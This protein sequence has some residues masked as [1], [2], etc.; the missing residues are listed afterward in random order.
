[1]FWL[2]SLLV[3]SVRPKRTGQERFLEDSQ[4]RTDRRRSLGD[5]MAGRR[6]QRH[7]WNE[8]IR[9]ALLDQPGKIL[10]PLPAQRHDRGRQRCRYPHLG[11][12]KDAHHLRQKTS[13]Q[14]GQQRLRRDENRR[15]PA[16]RALTWKTGFR[17]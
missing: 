7:A 13:S 14:R 9:G 5:L 4:R 16:R 10:R 12:E 11:S 6:E 1:Q 3:Q 8:S 15:R 17:E 2:R